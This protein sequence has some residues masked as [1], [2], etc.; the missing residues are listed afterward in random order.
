MELIEE[1]LLGK[2]VPY[3]SKYSPEILIAVPRAINR[4]IYQIR[5]EA[6][7]FTGV[8][9]WHAWEL[10]FLTTKGLPV[11]GILKLIYPANSQYLVESKSLKLYLNA[12]NME[13][14]GD[15]PAEGIK[16][17]LEIVRNDLSKLL[18]CEVATAFFASSSNPIQNDF[19]DFHLLESCNGIEGADFSNYTESPDLLKT[20]IESPATIK[21][22]THL[23]RSNCKITSQPDWGTVFIQVNGGMLPTCLSLLR[24]IVSLRDENHFHEEICELIYK[25]LN[26]RY[27]PEELMVACIYTRRGGIDICPV[28]VSHENLLPP[29]L[30][31]IQVLS[32]KLARQ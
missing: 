27:S 32:K 15:T 8:D 9:V 23:L 6:L 25:R 19:N 22:Y 30:S 28:R 1:S 17:V 5:D 2:Q 4:A 12:L 20:D 31:N 26:D 13:R 21:V 11:A 7:P 14:Y 29:F 18:K 16:L 24:Y 3:P 10:G